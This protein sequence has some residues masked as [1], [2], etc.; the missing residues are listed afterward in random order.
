MYWNFLLHKPGRVFLP[1]LVIV[2]MLSIGS[3]T[4]GYS[5]TDSGGLALILKFG[6]LGGGL[7]L[8]KSIA[9]PLHVRVGAN[10][11]NFGQNGEIDQD[12]E[13]LAYDV[14]MKLFSA[15]AVFDWYFLGSLHL[16]AGAML[17]QNQVEGTVKW[18][19]LSRPFFVN[20]MV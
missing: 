16:S 14:K 15:S 4:I 7:E 10:F 1:C 11:F 5:Q 6:T 17:N 18:T 12:G 3:P 8:V 13:T 20:F 19:P 2:L 9:R